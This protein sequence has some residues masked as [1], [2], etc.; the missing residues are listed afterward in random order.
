MLKFELLKQLNKIEGTDPSRAR[1]GTITTDHGIIQTPIFMPVGTLGSVKSISVEELDHCRAQIILGNTYHLYLRPGCEVIKHME[2]LHEFIRW[3]K[4]M[5][6]DSGGFQFFSLAKLAKFSD[7]GVSF[8]SHIDGSRH[9][10]S[11][12]KAV[13]IQM[14]LG[15]DIM[16][17]LDFCMGYPA[18][19][20]Q[21]MDA[22]NKTFY[23]A[24]RGFDFWQEKGTSNNLFGIIQGGMSKQFRSLSAGQ[25]TGID[26]PGFAIGGLSVGEP[27]DLMYEMADHTL[28]LMPVHKPRY[29]MGVGTPEDLVELVGMGCD[30]FDC[31]MP[32]RN[33]RNGQ[34]FTS[35]GT[36]NIP[37]ARFRF[38]K[39]PIDEDC[40]CYT[41][42]NYSKS[43][44]R[45]LYKSRELLSYRLNTIHNIYYYLDLMR[46]MRE[47]IAKD[48]FL[49]FKRNFYSQRQ[50]CTM[51]NGEL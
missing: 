40:N 35:K 39:D 22:V 7:E 1:L 41:C 38:D 16:M 24:K 19:E 26:F 11:P 31:V 46:K 18:S 8:Q 36:I 27:K 33:A 44:L 43:Y 13:E 42:Q 17:S 10:F 9:F 51:V 34:L 49:E 5:L 50:N 2:G 30:M 47:A 29:I 15:S 12:E 14:I 21:T 45:H 3:D 48:R 23:W 4:P 6:T 25:L 28:P 37:N 32:S 20:K